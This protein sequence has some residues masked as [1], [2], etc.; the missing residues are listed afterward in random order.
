M[1][2]PVHSNVCFL[3]KA[4]KLDTRYVDHRLIVKFALA[5]F[6]IHLIARNKLLYLQPRG[7]LLVDKNRIIRSEHAC[8]WE[9]DI[10][11][12]SSFTTSVLFYSKFSEAKLNL[13]LMIGSICEPCFDHV[14]TAKDCSLLISLIIINT[15]LVFS[16]H[17]RSK[18][19]MEKQNPILMI[20]QILWHK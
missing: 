10:K 12:R 2:V 8:A 17:N 5:V 1:Y 16:K 6:V 11:R 13:D 7:H 19:I 3:A 4:R 18:C 14:H 15:I 9:Q 20:L